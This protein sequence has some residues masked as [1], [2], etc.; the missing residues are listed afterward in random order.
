MVRTLRII[1]E[2]DVYN[3]GFVHGPENGLDASPV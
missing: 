1:A 3:A 2:D